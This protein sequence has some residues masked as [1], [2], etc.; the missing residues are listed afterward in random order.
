MAAP[1]ANDIAALLAADPFYIAHRGGSASWPEM[2]KAAYDHAAVAGMRALEISVQ[3]SSDG[4][5]V[6]SHDPSTLRVTGVDQQIAATSWAQL[7]GLSVRSPV[8]GGAPAAMTRLETV[9]DAYAGSRVIFLED[10]TYRNSGPLLELVA[11][12]PDYRRHF[13]WKVTGTAGEPVI[14]AGRTAGIPSWGYFFSADMPQFADRAGQFDWVGVDYQCTDAQLRQAAAIGKPMIGHIVSKAAQRD[15]LL[16]AGCR[17]IM[18][19]D[20]AGL[21]PH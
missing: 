4:V 6:C 2:T 19:A 21:A 10:K 1:A 7:S 18:L 3:R 14:Q 12:Y 9:L 17:G 13:F 5:F 15:R 11:R 20:V 8:A 16:A